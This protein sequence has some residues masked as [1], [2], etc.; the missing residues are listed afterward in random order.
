MLVSLV[1]VTD[2][3]QRWSEPCSISFVRKLVAYFKESGHTCDAA[4]FCITHTILLYLVYLIV[5]GASGAVLG[6]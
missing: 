2:L 4:G 3:G 1:G 5:A 6:S